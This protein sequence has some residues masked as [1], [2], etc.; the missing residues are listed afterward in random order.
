MNLT[1]IIDIVENQTVALGKLGPAAAH[2]LGFSSDDSRC[3]MSSSLAVVALALVFWP[4]ASGSAPGASPA[5]PALS[6]LVPA[7][8]YPGGK[9]LKDWERLIAA[10]DSVPIIAIINRDS[11]PGKQVDENLLPRAPARP[12]VEANNDRLCS[13]Q[14]R[15]AARRGGESRRRRLAVAVP[16]RARRRLL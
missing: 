14:V 6:L 13:A 8:I 16:G 1:K 4:T 3:V 7:Y 12:A 5:E 2:R 11:G 15:Q 10:A 9:G